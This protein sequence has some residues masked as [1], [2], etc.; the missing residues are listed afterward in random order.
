MVTKTDRDGFLKKIILAKN[1]EKGVKNMRFRACLGNLT[2]DFS[3]FWYV[4]SLI[5]YFRY[6]IGSLA[7]KIE[8]R[9]KLNRCVKRLINSYP[10]V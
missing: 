2:S 6:G 5:Y 10:V 3:Y 7:K 4:T 1:G 8:L 9:N